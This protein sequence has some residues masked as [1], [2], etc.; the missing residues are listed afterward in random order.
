[1]KYKDRDGQASAGGRGRYP[2][3]TVL[4]SLRANARRLAQDESGAAFV[5]TLGIFLFMWVVCSGVFAIGESVRRKIQIQNAADAAAYSAA[6]VQ[7]DTLSRIAT[8]NRAM[9]WTYIQMTRRQMDY[10]VMKWIN[11]AQSRIDDDRKSMKDWHS[12]TS[13][14]VNSTWGATSA[15]CPFQHQVNVSMPWT[16]WCGFPAPLLPYL[17]DRMFAINNDLPLLPNIFQDVVRV[18]GVFN[19]LAQPMRNANSGNP[20][21]LAA[22]MA[23][24]ETQI[25]FDKAN[26]IA[27][28][29]SVLTILLEY[30]GKVD[31]TVEQVVKA[32]LPQELHKDV[33]YACMR[34]SPRFWFSPLRN[35]KQDEL[36]FMAFSGDNYVQRVR[37]VF[38]C[39]ATG[40]EDGSKSGGVN[41]WFVR[42]S[43]SAGEKPEEKS[44]E[45]SLGIFRA[46]RKIQKEDQK[47]PGWFRYA[48]KNSEIDS[49]DG[50]WDSSPNRAAGLVA[51][52]HHNAFWWPVCIHLDFS[53]FFVFDL[54][55]YLAKLDSCKWSSGSGYVDGV[56][57]NCVGSG[58]ENMIG[59]L[60][61]SL[62]YPYPLKSPAP[63][64]VGLPWPAGG[65]RIYGD[66]PALWS[67]ITYTGQRC[68]PLILSDNIFGFFGKGGSI[69]VG[70]A[71]KTENAWDKIFGKASEGI[72]RAFDPAPS[73]THQWAVSA[74]R[75]GYKKWPEKDNNE[76]TSD[77]QLGYSDDGEK[78]D[79][80]QCWNLR[81]TDWDA[82]FVPVANAWDYCFATSPGGMAMFVPM[83]L[84]G[85][86]LKTLMAGG[87]WT[88]LAG[89]AQADWIRTPPSAPRGMT[90][91][92]L[93]WAGLNGRLTH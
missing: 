1:M 7:A 47:K 39:G 6:V 58:W 13:V 23:F 20:A 36:R 89:S 30:T 14:K 53:P 9:S 28:N 85:N 91:G 51:E 22:N 42:C 73:V 74:A 67:R 64:T 60:E 87:D 46:Y 59:L 79:F 72:F 12:Q 10:I 54:H 92:E 78:N 86:P 75:A 76:R 11:L 90:G 31:T 83:P 52:W 93:N 56:G 45:G 5:V 68:Y 34:E 62:P 63:N 65:G 49:T 38:N 17:S 69:V 40:S 61:G 2:R 48:P 8:V 70:V 32:N 15:D 3:I 81:Q 43:D 84:A 4:D 27:M 37:E 57:H 44:A 35:C 24:P 80:S 16:Y 66:D 19:R 71:R 26:I 25:L 33:L 88:P 29:V 82:L 41:H 50:A 21:T 55:V 77:Y 18:Y